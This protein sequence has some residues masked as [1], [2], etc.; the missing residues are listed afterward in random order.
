LATTSLWDVLGLVIEG[1]DWQALARY[2]LA[3]GL[4]LAMPAL[5]TGLLDLRRLPDTAAV[6]RAAMLHLTLVSGALTLYL[7][8]LILRIKYPDA[9]A[10]PF[11]ALLGFAWLAA[12]GFFGAELVYRHGVAVEREAEGEPALEA[13]VEHTRTRKASGTVRVKRDIDAA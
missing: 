6:G 13:A 12:G 4:V 7:T 8:S 3:L 5:V 2:N 9:S 1:H 10:A 11:V